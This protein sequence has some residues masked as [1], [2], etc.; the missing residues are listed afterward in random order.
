M[1]SLAQTGKPNHSLQWTLRDEAAAPLSYNVGVTVNCLN[2]RPKHPD[3]FSPT[4][5][6]LFLL[7]PCI[8][9]ALTA[10]IH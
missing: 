6:T 10:Q 8:V 4:C 2:D 5:P 7:C 3:Q 9:T 1:H